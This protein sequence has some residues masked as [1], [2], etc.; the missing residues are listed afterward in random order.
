VTLVKTSFRDAPRRIIFS[1]SSTASLD[2]VSAEVGEIGGAGS[3]RDVG[4]LASAINKPP[5]SRCY[6]YR[7]KKNRDRPE[8]LPEIDFLQQE[9]TT[10]R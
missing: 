7:T 6:K 8:S 5:I 3:C 2:R 10:Y 9:S 1:A 4:V